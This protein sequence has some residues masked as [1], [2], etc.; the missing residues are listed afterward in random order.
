MDFEVDRYII[1]HYWR[2]PLEGAPVD[3]H[4]ARRRSDNISL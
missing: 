4:F 1:E 3:P 2:T